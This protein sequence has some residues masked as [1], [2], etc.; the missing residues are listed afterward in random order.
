M[1]VKG[2]E[3]YQAVVTRSGKELDVSMREKNEI[4]KKEWEKE[5]EKD[6][7]ESDL[8]EIEKEKRKMT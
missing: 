4:K 7:D 6:I 5:K 8:E 2:K 1:E 3:P